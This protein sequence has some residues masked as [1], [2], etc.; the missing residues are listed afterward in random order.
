MICWAVLLKSIRLT[1]KKNYSFVPGFYP[2][3]SCLSLLGLLFII[4]IPA[5]H[6]DALD[7][8]V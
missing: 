2:G 8:P 1:T 7:Y 4:I 3:L 5:S 6:S